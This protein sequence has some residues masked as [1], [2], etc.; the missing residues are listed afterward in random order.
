M[1]NTEKINVIRFGKGEER[2]RKVK[3][4]WKGKEIEIKEVGYLR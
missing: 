2:E 4:W 3:W 1:L